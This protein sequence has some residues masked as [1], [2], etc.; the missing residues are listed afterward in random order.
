MLVPA[1]FLQ[2]EEHRLNSQSEIFLSL[3]GLQVGENVCLK[4]FDALFN[5]CDVFLARILE[6]VDALYKNLGTLREE[7][8]LGCQESPFSHISH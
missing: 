5:T 7:S 4:I 2:L 3:L 1:C 6:V 8:H